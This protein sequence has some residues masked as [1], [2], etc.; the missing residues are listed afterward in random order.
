MKVA[1]ALFGQPRFLNNPKPEISHKNFIMDKYDTDVFIHT[2]WDPNCKEY[3]VSSWSTIDRCPS[4]KN[5]I[6]II[7]EKFNPKLI[8]YE[9]PRT[10]KVKDEIVKVLKEKGPGHPISER[11]NLSNSISQLYT[12]EEAIKLYEKYKEENSIDYDFIIMSRLD[13]EILDF[14]DLNTL[15]TDYFY[16]SDHHDSF[17]DLIYLC[18]SKFA[19]AFK[20]YSIYE[21]ITYDLPKTDINFYKLCTFLKYY[22][23][24]LLRNIKL[25]VEIV[26]S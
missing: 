23:K 10:F 25:P 17:P 18:G 21:E 26:R 20:S 6:E 8:K 5:A 19:N 7:K 3:D 15:S 1:L 2:W 12:I 14:P 11:I 24:D 9:T 13:G 4:D 16:V 22:D